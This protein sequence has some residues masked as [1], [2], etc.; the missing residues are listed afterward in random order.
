MQKE[1]NK[2]LYMFLKISHERNKIPKN[3]EKERKEKRKKEKKKK[4]RKGKKEIK[5]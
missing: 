1:S 3:K 4:E 2:Y 5:I